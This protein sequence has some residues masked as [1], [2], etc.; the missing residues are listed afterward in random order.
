[1]PKLSPK[2][3]LVISFAFI[4]IIILLHLLSKIKQK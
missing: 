2:L 4:F 1:M 3:V